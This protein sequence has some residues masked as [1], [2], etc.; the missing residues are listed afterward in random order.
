M[1]IK[2]LGWLACHPASSLTPR[3]AV[4]ALGMK[5]RRKKEE[6][7][8]KGEREGQRGKEEEEKKREKQEA[9]RYPSEICRAHS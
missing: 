9:R 4:Y 7:W 8:M 2:M 6:E 5:Q 3:L 1:N